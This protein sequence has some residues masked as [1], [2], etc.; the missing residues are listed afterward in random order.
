MNI[1]PISSIEMDKY[2]PA[3]S[4]AQVTLEHL[5]SP[6]TTS[7]N[8][9]N[10]TNEIA[11]ALIKHLPPGIA[12]AVELRWQMNRS[13]TVIETMKVEVR[14][15]VLNSMGMYVTKDLPAEHDSEDNRKFYYMR[16]DVI[17]WYHSSPTNRD[18]FQIPVE[19]VVTIEFKDNNDILS[20][21]LTEDQMIGIC[22]GINGLGDKLVTLKSSITNGLVSVAD[23]TKHALIYRIP[24]TLATERLKRPYQVDVLQ[25]DGTFLTIYFVNPEF[26]QGIVSVANW[27]QL[28]NQG[29]DLLWKNL[30]QLTREE[31]VA[32]EF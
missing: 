26:M 23:V 13:P 21:S 30:Y 2:L 6:L 17:R 9:S 31:L 10:S 19:E 7:L 25:S 20:I 32:L 29:K 18:Y 16:E 4:R 1:E 15:I 12:H 14:Q 28:E 22:Y 11:K 8:V 24:I 3:D 5:L 27:Y